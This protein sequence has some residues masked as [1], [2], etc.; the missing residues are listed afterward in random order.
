MVFYLKKIFLCTLCVFGLIIPHGCLEK[1]S[2]NELNC[3]EARVVRVID[4]DTL[5]LQDGRIVRLLGVNAPERDESYY[6]ES[7]ERLIEL[8]FGKK[9]FLEYD[10]EVKKRSEC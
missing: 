8:V 5:E 7:K 1:S 6:L 4:G 10:T 9:V 2:R 3:E